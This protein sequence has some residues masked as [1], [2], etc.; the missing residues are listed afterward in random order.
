[1]S[2]CRWCDEGRPFMVGCEG[3]Q[4]VPLHGNNEHDGMMCHASSIYNA[5]PSCPTCGKE[6]TYQTPDGTFWDSN[7]HYWRQSQ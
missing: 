2:K 3:K 1:M 4:H 5:L 7:A 6:A